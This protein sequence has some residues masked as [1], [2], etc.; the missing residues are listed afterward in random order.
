MSAVQSVRLENVAVNSL[1]VGCGARNRGSRLSFF[2]ALV[3]ILCGG[4]IDAGAQTAHFAGAQQVVAFGG[5]S[6]PQGVAVD[7]SGN[8]YIADVNNYRVVK[9]PWTGGAYGPLVTLADRTT[10]GSIFEPLAWR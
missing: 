6:S 10:N 3:A 2:I 5:L 9:V 4:W 1:R 7:G 8:V